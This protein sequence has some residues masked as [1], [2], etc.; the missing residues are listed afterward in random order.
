MNFAYRSYL[1][2]LWSESNDPPIYRAILESSINGE[3]HGFATMQALFVFLEQDVKRFAG[4]PRLTSH[5][6]D[7]EDLK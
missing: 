4:T 2:R 5:T 7:D 3:R 6:D 1:L